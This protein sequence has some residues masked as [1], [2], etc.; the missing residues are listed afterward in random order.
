MKILLTGGLGYI[1]SHIAYLLKEKAVIIDNQSNSKLDFKK[2][3][4]KSKV[5]KLDLNY[6]NLNKIFNENNIK[7]VIHLA[8][9]KSVEQS[10]LYP[11][12][13]YKNNVISSLDLLEAMD[14]FK[15]N[16][17]IFSSS[18]TVYGDQN[19][20]PFKENYP[21]NATNPYG[22]NK[23]L[24]EKLISDYSKTNSSFKCFSL[25]YFNP[26]GADL[27]SGLSDQPL[28]NPLNLIPILNQAIKNKK[29]FR[30]FG[31][32]YKTKDGTCIRD[33]IHV[34]DLARAHIAA[35]KNI[36][37][38]K[39]HEPINL[40]LGSGISV[41]DI[42]QLYERIN[43][44]KI[45]YIFNK[46]RKGDISISYANNKKAL[47]LLDWKPNFSYEDMVHD[48]WLSYNRNL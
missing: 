33:F 8:G 32:D 30:V 3:I 40:G 25:R 44:V 47:D 39:G 24:I 19:R 36:N 21:L 10:E 6:L 42:I 4:P 14:N 2:Y 7:S 46:R 5:Y 12:K 13:Y 26:I 18:A 43:K 9:F 23:I 17:L 22:N 16:K 37:K 20:A 27:S 38:I 29:I 31:N 34:V 48:S 15:I 1:G 41:M 35:L 28:G 45:K 11:I